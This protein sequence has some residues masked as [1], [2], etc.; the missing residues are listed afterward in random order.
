CPRSHS[1]SMAEPGRESRSSES[2]TS[3]LVPGQCCHS[4]SFMLPDGE[5]DFPKPSVQGLQN[6]DLALSPPLQV[7]IDGFGWPQ[8]EDWEPFTKQN[9]D[10]DWNSENPWL[11][12]GITRTAFCC[13]ELTWVLQG[14]KYTVLMLE[15]D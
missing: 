11:K 7:V 8:C 14:E 1:R 15:G 9:L 5:S 3:A 6:S 2:W 4:A 10:A 13:S 12:P